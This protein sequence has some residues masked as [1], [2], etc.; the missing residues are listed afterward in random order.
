M[1]RMIEFA[2]LEFRQADFPTKEHVLEDPTD[3]HSERERERER[4][5][6]GEEERE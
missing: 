1:R 3:P 4:E 2:T 6:T 5:G